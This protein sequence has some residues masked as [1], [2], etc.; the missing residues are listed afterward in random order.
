[1]KQKSPSLPPPPLAWGREKALSPLFLEKGE[2][3]CLHNISLTKNILKDGKTPCLYH[4][5]LLKEEKGVDPHPRMGGGVRVW[6]GGNPQLPELAV[7]HWAVDHWAAAYWSVTPQG[8]GMRVVV[9][10]CLHPLSPVLAEVAPEEWPVLIRPIPITR[11]EEG[12]EVKATSMRVSPP[13][14]KGR[15]GVAIRS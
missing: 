14:P 6:E 10:P 4:P 15:Q 2:R 8:I 3:T 1:M 13:T 12:E 9:H 5:F 11:L 7:G